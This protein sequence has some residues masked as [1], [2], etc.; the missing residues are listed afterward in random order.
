MATGST[1]LSLALQF[2]VIGSDPT[3]DVLVLHPSEVGKLAPDLFGNDETL[4][5]LS[6]GNRGPHGI[7]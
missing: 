1:G 2:K 4:A 5:C 6:C 3:R 7:P